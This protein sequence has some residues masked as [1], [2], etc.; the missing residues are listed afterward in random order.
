MRRSWYRFC[1]TLCQL[2]LIWPVR[3]RVFGLRYVPRSGGALLVANHQSFFDPVLSAVALPREVSFMARDT[4]FG[5]GLFTR[6]IVSLNAFPV[7][8]GSAD[9]SAMKEALRR[10]RSGAALTV[11]PE[12][13]RTP[14]GSIQAMQAGVMLLARRSNVPLVPTLIL[15]A[16][17][18]WPRKRKFPLPGPILVA[19]APPLTP[20]KYAGLDDESCMRIVRGRIVDLARRYREHPHV[21][22]VISSRV[23]RQDSASPSLE[24]S[25]AAVHANFTA[26]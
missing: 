25:P 17:E 7:K 15:G 8:R 18:A 23:R 3:L 16:F 1:Q 9:L 24:N 12:G 11:F 26:G 22:R 13:T 10:L 19:Y 20:Q 6:L 5:S 21:R 4:L 2:A 14:D